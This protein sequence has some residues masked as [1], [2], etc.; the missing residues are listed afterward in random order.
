VEAGSLDLSGGSQLLS[1][2]SGSGPGGAIQLN[3][4]TPRDLTIAFSGDSLITSS[5]SQ[6]GS[7][8]GKGGDIVVGTANQNLS[9]NGAG[10][11]TADTTGSGD[12]GSLDFKGASIA[13]KDS[14]RAATQ[15]SGSGRGGSLSLATGTLQ[16]DPGTSLS[17]SA[18]ASGTGGAITVAPSTSAPLS[19]TGSGL[20]ETTA[21]GSGSAGAIRIGTNDTSRPPVASST[22]LSGGVRLKTSRSSVDLSSSGTTNVQGGSI[23]ALGSSVQIRGDQDVRLQGVDIRALSSTVSPANEGSISVTGGAI[24]VG[25]ASERTILLAGSGA[26]KAGEAAVEAPNLTL[27]DGGT[28]SAAAI[29]LTGG[30]NKTIQIF[31]GAAAPATAQGITNVRGATAVTATAPEVQTATPGHRIVVG[32][33]LAGPSATATSTSSATSVGSGSSLA[34]HG[35]GRI[36]VLSTGATSISGSLS[37]ENS[38]P[39][40]LLRIDRPAPLHRRP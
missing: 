8:G 29:T 15:T 40:R 14:V 7:G 39:R 18:T 20:I 38:G 34:A 5:T 27:L 24:E 9:I 26:L 28:G 13:L 6:T 35:G 3:S 22:T 37:S 23:E 11:M 2:A 16:L 30:A 31:S 19:I 17:S 33:V 12:G 10:R 1:Q 36:D 21:T 4:T 32:G 25:K